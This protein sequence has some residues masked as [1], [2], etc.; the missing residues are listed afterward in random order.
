MEDGDI[1]DNSAESDDDNNSSDESSNEIS[2]EIL[3]DNM[4][5]SDDFAKAM[6]RLTTSGEI[7]TQDSTI[8][9]QKASEFRYCSNF[10]KINFNFVASFYP[11]NFQI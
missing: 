6:K 2:D 5:S 3:S 10:K 8:E 1:S 4:D 11:N 7:V 9:C